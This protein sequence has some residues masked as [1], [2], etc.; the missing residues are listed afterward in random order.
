MYTVCCIANVYLEQESRIHRLDIKLPTC[1]KP[2]E[3]EEATLIHD[4]NKG[5]VADA[6]EESY[7]FHQ[8]NRRSGCCGPYP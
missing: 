7:D 3:A 4:D 8:I 1:A 2:E 6:I 5:A